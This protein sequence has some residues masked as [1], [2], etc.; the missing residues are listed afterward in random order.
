MIQNQVGGGSG[1]EYITKTFTIN[2]TDCVS[3]QDDRYNSHWEYRKAPTDKEN[4]VI[5]VIKNHSNYSSDSVIAE[6]FIDGAGY[7]STR[8]STYNVTDSHLS[9]G[10]LSLY[11]M[12]E[13]G[14]GIIAIFW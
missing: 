6:Y 14:A 1:I 11:N 12:N 8:K 9:N 10:T 13:D 7:R 4:Y 5:M 2:T 3:V